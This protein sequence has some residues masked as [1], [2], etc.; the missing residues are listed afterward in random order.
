MIKVNYGNLPI[1]TTSEF[2]EK[3]KNDLARVKNMPSPSFE[4]IKT[5]LGYI[6]KK[7]RK[8]KK[9]KNIILIGSGGSRAS[10]MAF[11][12]ALADF[13]NKINFEFINS[14]EPDLITR[15]RKKYSK[16]ETLVLVV[17]KGGDNINALEPLLLLADYPVLVITGE[18]ESVLS[19]I[20]TK[21][22]W[23]I[24]LHPE[25]GGRFAGMTSCGLAAAYL[26]GLD[27]KKIYQGAESSYKRYSLSADLQRNDA[28]KL[29]EYFYDLEQN[30]YIEIFASFYSTPLFSFL[31][32][33]IQL[34]HESTGKGG[35]GQ[36]IFGDY[37]PESQHH[38]NQ[39]F[40][41]GRKNIAGLF[42]GAE[43]TAKDISIKISKDLEKINLDGTDLKILNNIKGSE[44]LRYDMEGVIKN[45]IDKNIP[46]A[47]I[48]IDI[49]TE[50]NIGEFMVFW[51]YFAVYS[52]ILREQN[53]YDQPEVE[54]S[55]AISLKLRLK[56]K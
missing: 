51:Q 8:Y 9:Y 35:K 18:K 20:T 26:M 3:Y 43:K 7:A 25:V 24:I 10:A 22:K 48:T 47:K 49:L 14:A 52:A 33:I 27:I 30:G 46:F 54:K 37:S 16:K 21:R 6:A 4:K 1:P 40:F 38:T 34:I 41:G 29:A 55:K 44:T 50:E 56:R 45:C 36:T 31:P 15:A 5:D 53:P 39:R 23:G 2:G 19:R 32:L 17:S 13:R 12:G 28:L 42:F 11:Y